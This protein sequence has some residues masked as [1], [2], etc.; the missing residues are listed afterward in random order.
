MRGA[1][2][3][4]LV[5]LSV[6]PAWAGEG[7]LRRAEG[8]KVDGQY[9]VVFEP[10]Q[11]A[12]QVARGLAGLHGAQVDEV[13]ESALHGALM[14][15]MTEAQAVALSKHPQVAWVEEDGIVRG[16]DVT[17][18]GAP[19]HLDRADQRTL[20]LSFS[21][22]RYFD[23]TDVHVYVLDSGILHTHNE[24]GGRASLDHDVLGGSGSD[25]HGHGTH[26][27]GIIGGAT[28]GIAKN[29]RLHS[30]RVL[31]CL[32]NGTVSG[33]ISG[34]NWVTANAVQPAVANMSL[35]A[36]ASSSL[37]TAVNNSVS[38]GIVYA[39]SAGNDGTDA[40]TRSPARAASAL[41]VGAIKDNDARWAS[42][43]YGT[44]VDLFAPGHNVI[45][46]W[47]SGNSATNILSGT[48]MASPVVA[49]IAA[50]IRDELPGWSAASVA[51]EV[52]AMATTGVVTSAGS[53]SPNRLAYSI[54][55][56]PGEPAT[57]GVYSERCYGLHNLSWTAVGGAVSYQLWE[58]YDSVYSSSSLTYSG[59]DNFH[60]V[61]V[62]Y[63]TYYRVRACASARCSGFR[64]SGNPATY[65]S[66]CL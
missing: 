57:F 54:Y 35:G 18:N 20:N 7:K 1:A 3:F 28:Y 40:C 19:W 34:V 45:S 33:A 65:Y 62:T 10:G 2:L 66:G 5:S 29:V 39:V 25:C 31:D 43:N 47:K 64:R 22:T 15:G 16:D 17:Q 8:R 48:S 12:S 26:V 59:S 36:P 32:N 44:C 4:L 41:T 11:R 14:K 13:W 58:S 61:N 27:A 30:V 60:S 53:G 42:S 56:S 52:L 50:L 24:F 21:Y 37:D 63:P 23:G 55:G 51:A 9:I 38:A 6:L 46:A 49:G